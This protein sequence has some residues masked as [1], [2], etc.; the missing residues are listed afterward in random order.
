MNL[1][2]K[3]TLAFILLVVVIVATI[4][5]IDLGN[6]LQLQFEGTLERADVI[7]PVATR[8]VMDTRNSQLDIPLREALR[9]TSLSQDL[10]DLLTNAKAILEIGIHNDDS[11]ADQGPILGAPDIK[12]V[13]ELGQG[14]RIDI[15]GL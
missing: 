2:A 8:F 15:A 14:F 5:V 11:F 4:S 13:D 9:A 10:L 3:L 6:I 7:N 12:D 1:Q